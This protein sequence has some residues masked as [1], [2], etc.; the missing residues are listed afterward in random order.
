MVLPMGPPA[1]RSIWRRGNHALL[2]CP[3]R[4]SSAPAK[5][6]IKSP[7]SSSP[8]LA[9]ANLLVCP[10]HRTLTRTCS[11]QTAKVECW[12]Y[13]ENAKCSSRILEGVFKMPEY[14]TQNAPVEYKENAKCPSGGRRM[15]NARAEYE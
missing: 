14:N 4:K 12:K 7:I 5:I 2:P 1:A 8:Y 9:F 11:A 6:V 10:I 13:K 3:L 15:Q